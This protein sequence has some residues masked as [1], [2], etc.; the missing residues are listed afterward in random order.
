MEVCYF[1]EYSQHI[2]QANL[3]PLSDRRPS[4]KKRREHH[5][6]SKLVINVAKAK[7]L[8]AKTSG[9]HIG[10]SDVK[11]SQAAVSPPS[12]EDLLKQDLI[13]LKVDNTTAKRTTV[14]DRAKFNLF[15]S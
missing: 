7:I 13:P 9:R 10:Q 1:D 11:V 14:Y 5:S 4:N 2:S 3:N 8:T 6:P 15:G 12:V